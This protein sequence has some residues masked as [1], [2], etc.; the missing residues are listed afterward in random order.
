MLCVQPRSSECRMS[1]LR[2]SL[3]L[4]M[5]VGRVP[6]AESTRHSIPQV[7]RSLARF[8]DP[9]GIIWRVN[10]AVRR[11]S[12]A[13]TMRFLQGLLIA[14]SYSRPILM[15]G[16]PRSGT[17]MLFRVLRASEQLGSL[18]T[19]GHDVWRR[20][21]HP[22]K[23]GWS[24]DHLGRGQIRRGE[25]RYVNAHFFAYAGRKRLIDK[26]ADNLVRI[27]YLLEM[28]PDAIFVVMKRNPCDAVNSYI[29][30]WRQPGGRFRS[31]YVPT[32]LDIPDY[33]QRRMW[34]STLI[35]GWRK[36]TDA[37]IPEI[38]FE[39][40]QQYVT[41]IEEGRRL[42]PEQQWVEF[43]LKDLLDYPERTS[44]WLFQRLGIEP[45]PAVEAELRELLGH[46][47]NTISPPAWE[48]W[49]TQNGAALTGLLPRIA[50]R[51]PALGCTVD[52]VTGFFSY[53][54]VSF[55]KRLDT[56]TNERRVRTAARI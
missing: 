43:F 22:R 52:P 23:T 18:P 14:P 53:D 7:P 50:E 25:R 32:D 39:Q 12:L 24:S 11:L 3:E 10:N 37:P 8:D 48:K 30:M 46:P 49:R 6:A 5:A 19:E 55:G 1:L 33:P 26:T 42:V 38:A 27:P 35:D 36:F 20:F 2:T 21:H 4:L 51:C 54:S 15:V 56:Q 40:W 31:Y 41:A 28:F 13:R 17:T 34:C 16:M 45:S 9:Y 44:R 29:N 47:V